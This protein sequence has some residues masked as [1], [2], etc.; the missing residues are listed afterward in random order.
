MFQWIRLGTAVP[1]ISL[2]NPSKN[3]EAVCNKIQEA[4]DVSLLVFPQ[5]C[6]TGNTCGDLFF[7]SA[8][9]T[10]SQNAIKKIAEQT[11][12]SNCVA[13]VCAPLCI[14][15]QLY[16]CAFVLHNGMIAGIVPKTYLS[17]EESR[18]FRSARELKES[19]L[20][21]NQFGFN[22]KQ[23]I[24][25]GN[26]LVFDC[27]SFRFGIELGEDAFSPVSPA[28]SLALNGA[29]IIVNPCA[30]LSVVGASYHAPQKSAQL[31]CAYAQ[32]STG[33][34]EST[35]DYVLSG[36]SMISELGNPLT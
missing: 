33:T 2:G 6:I 8:L 19:F 21:P 18:W 4:K 25:V 13:V 35:T 11:K 36:S 15:Q 5:L 27:Q 20:E 28:V 23:P 17:H 34:G 14:N 30:T 9:Q 22:Q 16:N 7:Q 3:A 1:E 10:D 31:L 29:D 12:K 24:P 32:T 26:D